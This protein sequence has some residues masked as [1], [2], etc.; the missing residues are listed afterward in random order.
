MLEY[1]V[2]L[3]NAKLQVTPGVPS[4]FV[5]NL[6]HLDAQHKS[7]TVL[8]EVNKTFVVTPDVDKLL[9]EL[10]L[11]GGMTPA[12]KALA[13]RKRMEKLGVKVTGK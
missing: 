11:N 9:Q 2:A 3:V 8:G 13:E 10:Y 5:Q 4:T 1:L 6:T 12:D 7:T